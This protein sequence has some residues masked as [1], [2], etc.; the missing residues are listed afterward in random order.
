MDIIL[1]YI[2]F[3]IGHS[4]VSVSRCWSYQSP[5]HQST[6]IEDPPPIPTQ[7]AC[8]LADFGTPVVC[9]K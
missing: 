8:I 5:L 4:V 7:P 3:D 1:G 9:V 2:K 6:N